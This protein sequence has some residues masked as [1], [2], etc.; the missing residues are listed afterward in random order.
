MTRSVVALLIGPICCDVKY[1]RREE[2]TEFYEILGQLLEPSR[3]HLL[4]V[5][6]FMLKAQMTLH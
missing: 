4:C 2:S 6:L 3:K 5:P 1:W